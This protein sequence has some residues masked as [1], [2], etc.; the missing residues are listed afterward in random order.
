MENFTDDIRPIETRKTLKL[1]MTSGAIISTVLGV[2]I[3]IIFIINLQKSHPFP[4]G[5]HTYELD[6]YAKFG[7]FVGGFIGTL[8]SLAGFFLLYLTFKDQRESF[9]RE[10]LENNYFEMISFHRDNVNELTYTYKENHT[11]HNFSTAER[12]KVFKIIF[13]QFKEAWEELSHFFDQ[14]QINLIYKIDYLSKLENNSTLNERKIDLKQYAQIDIIYTIIFFGL[15]E[16]DRETIFNIFKEKYNEN[17]IKTII[18]YS[19][20]KPKKESDFWRKWQLINNSKNKISIFNKINK[21]RNDHKSQSILFPK[22]TFST[23]QIKFDYDHYYPDNYNKYYGGH[24]FRL[25]HY[26]R[27]FFQTVNF[28][29]KEIYL[30]FDEKYKY[31]KILR[32]QLSNYEQIIF[33]LSS[34]SEVGRTW[35]FETKKQES[36]EEN[37][38][39]ITKYNL[40]KNIPMKIISSEIFVNKYYPNV[41]FETFEN[42]DG[43]TKRK[44]IA[45]KYY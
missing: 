7:D 45:Q 9:H 30:T 39:L 15:S 19:I 26:F 8:F 14:N 41:E 37:K 20:L 4:L 34:I 5:K 17:F 16:E 22:G 24:Q 13:T 42:G 11:D 6:N 36:I 33:F 18:D 38:Q 35:E 28:I 3:L 44:K 40:I 31:I 12:R 21:Q 2:T 1:I 32:S 10:R 43:L 23:E 29:D 27:H 25:G